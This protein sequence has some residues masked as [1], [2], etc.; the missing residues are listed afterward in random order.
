MS[1]IFVDALVMLDGEN[2]G[3]HSYMSYENA[4]EIQACGGLANAECINLRETEDRKIPQSLK[5]G[6]ACVT[7]ILVRLDP[8][9]PYFLN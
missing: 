2:G 6:L 7:D 1:E 5:E 9:I 4:L 3:F 8:S